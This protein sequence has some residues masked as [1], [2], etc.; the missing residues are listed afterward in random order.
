MQ[1]NP[2]IISGPSGAGEDSIINGLR[3]LFPVE[4]VVTTTTRPMRANEIEGQSYYFFTKEEFQNEISK[5]KFFEWAQ[6][7]NDNLYGVTFEEIERVKNSGKVGL[8]KLEYKGVATAKKLIPDITAIFINAPLD[9]LE[10]RIRMRDQVTEEFILERISYTKE[11]L[12]HKDIY[13]Y[14]INNE[15]GKLADSIKQVA[16]IIQK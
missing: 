6:Q 13:D 9:Q 5:G 12:K 10:Q 3:E 11:W 2:F 16:Q 1:N 4:Q 7:Y 8:W 15:N 14:E